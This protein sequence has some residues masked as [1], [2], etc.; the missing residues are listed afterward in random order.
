MLEAMSSSSAAAVTA[1]LRPL[2]L[3]T[4]TIGI[5]AVLVVLARVF[6]DPAAP[7]P[8]LW[9]IGVVALALF[10]AAVLLRQVGYA[11]PS[12]PRGLP[13]EN[14]AETSVRYF[15][16][17]T[18]L[19]AAICEAPVFVG[20]FVSV[21]TPHTWLP[22]ALALPGSVAL[23]WVH[24]WPSARTVA[25]VAEGL[26]RDGARSHLAEALGLHG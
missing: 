22:L 21:L 5:G 1:R 3:L 8:S 4:G 11:V 15:S 19:R 25:A 10:G 9:Q 23:F 6:I 24:A 7:M 17:T 14:A 12:L 26:E 20:L 16:S 18:V 13:E 2:Q